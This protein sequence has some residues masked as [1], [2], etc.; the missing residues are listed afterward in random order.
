MVQCLKLWAE[1]VTKYRYL[2][3][4]YICYQFISAIFAEFDKI[5]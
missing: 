3:W 5:S 1:I 2:P 4:K